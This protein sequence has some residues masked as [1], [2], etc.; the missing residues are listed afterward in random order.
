[1]KKTNK[2][3][4]L[5]MAFVLLIS[6]FVPVMSYA[7]DAPTIVTT[8]V[9]GALQKGSRKTFDVWAKDSN[10]NKIDSFVEFNNLDIYP[11][12]DDMEKTSYTLDFDTEGE[13]TVVVSATADG[14]TAT[15]TYS[16][17]YQRALPGEVIG[18]SVW[19][20]EKFTIGKGYVIEPVELDI[21]EGENAAYMLDRLIN[22]SDLLYNHGGSLDSGF[23]LSSIKGTASNPLDLDGAYPPDYLLTALEENWYTFDPGNASENALGEFNYTWASGWMYCANNVFPNV[24]FADYYPSEDD[25]LRVQFTLAFGSDIGG[26]S[27]MGWGGDGF[28]SVANKDRLISAIA[29]INSSPDKEAL[30]ADEDIYSYY[31]TAIED[32]LPTLNIEQ[33]EVD[34]VY[35]ELSALLSSFGETDVNRITTEELEGYIDGVIAWARNTLTSYNNGKLLN[36]DFLEMAGSTP[37]DWFPMSIGRY[38]AEDDYEA[39]L[40]AIEDYVTEKYKNTGVLLDRNK[41]TEWHRISLAILALGGDPTCIG[42]DINGNPINLIAD[43]TYNRAN[44]GRQGIN[45]WI[46]GLIALNS[47]DFEIPADAINSRETF[48]SEIMKLQRSDGGFSLTGLSDPDITFMTVLSLSKDYFDNDAKYPAYSGIEKTVKQVVDDA[49]NLMGTKQQEDGDFSSWGTT[50][51]EST[52]WGLVALTS[53]GIDCE[54]DSRFIKD[55]KTLIDGILKYQNPND[56]GFYHSYQAD[57]QNPSA[58]PTSSNSMATEQTLYGLISY[59]K[60]KNGQHTFFDFKPE[61]KNISSVP[62]ITINQPWCGKKSVIV[63][64]NADEPVGLFV[65]VNAYNGN[66]LQQAVSQSLAV[67][68]DKKTYTI[69]YADLSTNGS[70]AVKLYLW[71]SLVDLKPITTAVSIK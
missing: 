30:L 36:P 67:T 70:D 32:V 43:G 35:N 68:P 40:L 45:G 58:D 61:A 27:A 9:D 42:Q 33:S 31:N 3:L 47:L 62:G 8:L 5:F 65:I 18:K 28:Y 23:Y 48:L 22:Q 24:G 10:G 66:R 52:V 34:E 29:K 12:W 57:S 11:T 46:W 54:T 13:N 15:L 16:I 60:L 17:I 19:C 55:G 4:G 71:N 50:N 26:S 37:G 64:I 21:L 53:L 63:D 69:S 41:A 25:V 14:Q 44:P 6:F 59:L 7:S 56:G 49:I 1:M 2:I 39:Y 20:I 38:G 51:V